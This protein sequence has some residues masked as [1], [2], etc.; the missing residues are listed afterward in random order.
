MMKHVNIYNVNESVQCQGIRSAGF[1]SD[2]VR[3]IWRV[4][5]MAWSII[6]I[7]EGLNDTSVIVISQ[8]KKNELTNPKSARESSNSMT[9]YVNFSVY[10]YYS[11][12][13]LSIVTRN[14]PKKALP[15]ARALTRVRKYRSGRVRYLTWVITGVNG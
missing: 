11:L 4:V 14:F 10:C 13:T 6:I 2:Q 8:A 5:W 9:I 15:P 3:V 1:S 7:Y 12:L